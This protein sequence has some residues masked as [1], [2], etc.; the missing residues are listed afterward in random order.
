MSVV[1]ETV[2]SNLGSRFFLNF[3]PRER[4]VAL[5]PLGFETSKGT[6]LTFA[7]RVGEDSRALPFTDEETV[8]ETVEQRIT[9]TSVTYL[10]RDQKLG[11][12]AEFRFTAPFYPGDERLSTA[13]VV[14]L[15]VTIEPLL[16]NGAKPLR[17]D[18]EGTIVVRL[19]GS[20]SSGGK[21]L[22]NRAY[23]NPAP[24]FQDDPEVFTPDLT[25]TVALAAIGEGMVTDGEIAAAFSLKGR[26]SA[27]AS[28]VFAGFAGQHVL[29]VMNTDYRFLYT[30]FWKDIDALVE[31]AKS[32]R[33]EW[34]SKAAFFD[35]LFAESSL[36]M[37]QQNLISFALQSF[38][39]NT[40]WAVSDEGKEWYS[41][42]EGNC[43]FHSTVDVEYN[44]AWF[45]IL[46]WPELLG[47]ELD[48]WAMFVNDGI[49]A[50][51]FGSTFHVWKQIYGHPM[52]IEENGNYLLLSHLYWRWTG[53]RSRLDRNY[54][55]MLE[56]AEYILDS[57]TTGNGFP[58]VGT[59][60]TI[61]DASAAVQYSKEQIYLGVKALSALTA[62]AAMS[63]AM[64]EE[65][66][67]ER[68]KRRVELIRNTLESEAWLGDHYAVCLDKTAEGIEDLP[69]QTP[70]GELPGWDAYSL[71]TSNGLL[72]LLATNT[73]VDVD[74]ERIKADLVNAARES[75]T[76]Y[77]CTHSSADHSNL[78]VSQN[79][80]R[81]YV[82]AYLGVDLM[83]MADR[84][85]AFEVYENAQG[86]G[87]WFVDTWGANH[88]RF[89]PRG[90]TSLGI[91]CAYGGV[92]Q[93]RVEGKFVVNPV[94]VPC[95]LPLLSQA[96][97]PAQDVPWLEYTLQDG[98]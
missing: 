5:S 4:Q 38:L 53:D 70:S 34:L 6:P 71:Y 19:P 75:M 16:G 27:S 95:K 48:E 1:Y 43:Q 76:E 59:A 32:E 3:K 31:S 17:P 80:H 21:L 46:L 92:R 26:K 97:W 39:A 54:G 93:D 30:K 20:K 72:Y 90:I 24:W 37:C 50:H 11:V 86:R 33:E 40:W 15:D 49:M 64:G 87:G 55:K 67:A 25:G 85:W 10:A 91:L 36:S 88:L 78:W 94:H 98:K 79:L 18:A 12:R 52:P 58:N 2:V 56:L 57:D 9:P 28:F 42:W 84:Y 13:P 62:M 41:V 89:Y 29:R 73:P 22:L 35:S 83:G 51:D 69:D 60:N 23:E 44:L 47:K 68:C 66:M 45:Y 61:D 82:G 77:G 14:Y 81:D 96:D 74:L 63:L 65:K 8:F 7:V